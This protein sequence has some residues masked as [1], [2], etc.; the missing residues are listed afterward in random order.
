MQGGMVCYTA[1]VERL[2]VRMRVFLAGLLLAAA[3]M[4]VAAPRVRVVALFHD[5]A[6]V[7]ID[8]RRQLLRA[9]Q[10]A[11]E[12]VRLISATTREAVLEVDGQRHRLGLSR[13]VGGSYRPSRGQQVQIARNERGMYVTTGSVNSSPMTFLVDT[14]ASTV[15]LNARDAARAGI[16]YRLR[17][18]RIGVQTAS[19]TTT[20]YQVMLDRVSVG[21]ITVP[22]VRATVLDGPSPQTP[23]LGMSF[24]GRLKLRHEGQLM[25]LEQ[26]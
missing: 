13:S 8:G 5:S 16:D 24:L 12:G 2:G 15:A 22:N 10:T 3:A 6:M 21:G 25:V 17:G 23:L 14:G 4:A 19:G 7:E 1:A 9:G 11:P 26:F 18:T 20:G